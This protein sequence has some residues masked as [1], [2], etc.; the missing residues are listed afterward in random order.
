[1]ENLKHTAKTLGIK[2]IHYSLQA[3]YTSSTSPSSGGSSFSQKP[4]VDLSL[5][6]VS[7]QSVGRGVV[8]EGVG[9]V[10]EG[11]C[12]VWEGLCVVWEGVGGFWEGV[13]VVWEAA[14]ETTSRVHSYKYRWK[15][16]RH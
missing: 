15:E 14:N 16:I 5:S 6:W 10:W 2:V 12:A 3:T 13:V 1:M 9:F 11:V 8:W 4:T 7:L